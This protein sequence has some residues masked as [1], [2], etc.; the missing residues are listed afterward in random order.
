MCYIAIRPVPTR[1]ESRAAP[2]PVSSSLAPRWLRRL[3]VVAA[4]AALALWV[5]LY[6]FLGTNTW[7]AALFL[8]IGKMMQRGLLLYRDLWEMKPPGMFFYQWAVFSVLPVEVWSLRFTDYALYVAAGVVFFHVCRVEARWPLALAGTG[9]WLYFAHHP[10]YNNNGFYTEE[11]ASIAAVFAVGA[12]LHFRRTGLLRWAA[13]SGAAV[14]LAGLSKHSGLSCGLPVFLLVCSRRPL[15]SLPLLAVSVALPVL[16]TVAYFW[17]L[18]ILEEFL[19]CN[20]YSVL[21]YTTEKNPHGP[22][23]M[24]HLKVLG[25]Q[26]ATRLLP[27]PVLVWPAVLGS[28]VAVLRPNLFRLVALAWLLADLAAVGAAQHY[29]EHHFIGIFAPAAVVGVIGAAWLLQRRP[30]E[31]WLIAVPRLALGVAMAA[32][33]WTWLRGVIEAR[34]PVVAEA[35]TALR[36]GPSAWPRNPGRSFELELGRW[37]S[38]RTTPDESIFIY[39]TGTMV[40]AYW[41]SDRKPASRYIYSDRPWRSQE[42]V[43]ELQRTRPAY[44]GISGDSVYRHYT[45]FLLEHYTPATVKWR[46]YRAEIWARNE[47][48]P[49][50]VGAS[51]GVVEDAKAGGLTLPGSQAPADAPL[52]EL[53]DARHGTWTSPVI[54][55]VGTGSDLALDWNPRANLA[56]NPSGIGWPSADTSAPAAGDA[57]AVLGTPT[58]NGYWITAPSPQPQQLTVRFGFDAVADRAVLHGA[59]NDGGRAADRLQVLAATNGE[60]APLAGTWEADGDGVWAYRFAPHALSALRLVAT[61]SKAGETVT[62]R[63]ML[64]RSAG[65]GIRVRYRSGATPDLDAAAWVPV[66]DRNE[67][68]VLVP[69]QRYVQLQYELWSR[70]DGRA[71]VLRAAQIGRLRFQLDAAPPAEPLRTATAGG[72]PGE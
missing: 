9:V 64:V 21:T 17:Q 33:G 49:F 39:D 42:Q 4:V 25:K 55:V 40:A 60:F 37:F 34:R 41:T 67:G 11:Y 69:V 61:P 58:R 59:L 15:L 31:R 3:A 54:A 43:T 28:V 13:V 12:A 29:Y 63:R 16:A 57:D 44:V 46:D 8:V 23:W 45:P 53:P 10:I 19:D 22:Q 56:H 38:E 30:G 6:E 1:L 51:A 20:Y 32:L 48:V 65:M 35:W 68:Q 7:D 36:T 71:P 50:A 18:G 47:L 66:N 70:Y 2:A 24:A 14:A 26:L 72:V 27:H 52:V 62:L 5:H